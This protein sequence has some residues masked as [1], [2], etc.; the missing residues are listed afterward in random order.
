MHALWRA[1]CLCHRRRGTQGFY[2][3]GW[4]DVWRELYLG[5][6][7]GELG[8]PDVGKLARGNGF[9]SHIATADSGFAFVRDFSLSGFSCVWV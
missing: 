2:S 6:I 9:G 7:W 1:G 3:L 8:N 4:L 5:H